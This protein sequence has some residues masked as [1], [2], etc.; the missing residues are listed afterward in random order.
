MLLVTA[1]PGLSADEMAAAETRDG[2]FIHLSSG[3]DQPSRVAMAL[4]LA[5]TFAPDRP[6]LLYADVEAVRLFLEDAVLP[7]PKGY[8][9]GA[10]LLNQ[11]LDA[12]VR[13]QVCPTCLK[14]R[15]FSADDL[16][17]GIVLADKAA[18]FSFTEGRILSVGY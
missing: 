12:G 13:I 5:N 8:D 11:L 7:A 17:S 15:G 16:K 3:P 1:G 14:A 10:T 18:F 2:L 4:T 9:A 6:V